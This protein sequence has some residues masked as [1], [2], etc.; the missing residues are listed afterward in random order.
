MEGVRVA[1]GGCDGL[2][3]RGLVCHVCGKAFYSR[4]RRQDLQRH[5]LSHT[6]ERPFPCPFC[7]YRASLKGN[8]KKHIHGLH[9]HFLKALDNNIGRV[10]AWQSAVV[11]HRPHLPTPTS[12]SVAVECITC[13]KSFYGFN[14]NFLLKRHMITHTVSTLPTQSKPETEFGSA[15]QKEA[16]RPAV[17]RAVGGATQDQVGAVLESGTC[18]LCGKH[19]PRMTSSWRQKLE[20][21]L[22][23][24]TGEKPYRCPYCPHRSGRKDSIKRHGRIMHPDKPPLSASDIGLAYDQIGV[25]IARQDLAYTTPQAVDRRRHE[26]GGHAPEGGIA[27]GLGIGL[28]GE[29]ISLSFSRSCSVCGHSFSGITWKQ[30]LE[31]HLLVHTG[32]KPFHC[33]Y[34]P[35]RTNRKDALKAH[36]AALHKIHLIT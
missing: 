5:L 23:T 14:R 6:G 33:P 31:R 24:H 35:H 26:P 34:C 25:D 22:L 12:P 11:A 2:E 1:P 30:K 29:K 27:G 19:F 15:H 28:G 10:T 36:V 7:P 4:N 17:L 9:A 18:P 20:R 32:E 13:G 21:H 8:L 16:Q 3:G